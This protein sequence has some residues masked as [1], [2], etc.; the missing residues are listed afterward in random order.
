MKIT[1]TNSF[2]RI[3]YKTDKLISG[4]DVT[5][6]I[7]NE[8]GI[9]LYD[10]EPAISEVGTEGVYYFELTTP[11][12][13]SYL[14]IIGSTSVGEFPKPQIIKVGN[15]D[16]KLFYVHGEFTAN[17]SISYEIHDE[18]GDVLSSGNLIN[19]TNAIYYADGTGLSEPWFFRVAPWARK[20]TSD[21]LAQ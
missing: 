8:N 5:F 12:T 14:L 6:N 21:T 11:L 1:D 19:V 9:K 20:N 13:D 18:N 7:W 15:P 4:L 3:F 2:L 16:Q 17:K 10:N